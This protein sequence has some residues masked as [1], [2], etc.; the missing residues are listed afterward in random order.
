MQFTQK[1]LFFHRNAFDFG[2]RM[3]TYRIDDEKASAGFSVLYENI[4]PE[5]SLQSYREKAPIYLGLILLVSAVACLLIGPSAHNPQV[6]TALG[7]AFVIAGWGSLL[8]GRFARFD[9]TVIGTPQGRILVFDREGKDQIVAEI[10]RRR[11]DEI[12]RKYL[13]VDFLNDPQ[14]EIAKYKWLKGEGIVSEQEFE[15]AIG[16]ITAARSERS[17]P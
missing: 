9:S 17:G 6:S 15:A 3:L 4:S 5:K 12:R 8:V 11:K 14:H 13:E 7:W 16:K 1:A 2:E 10:Y